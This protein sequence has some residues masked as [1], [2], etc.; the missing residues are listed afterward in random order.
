MAWTAFEYPNP[1]R[2]I[3]QVVFETM[4]EDLHFERYDVT[5][6]SVVDL[7]RNTTSFTMALS[8]VAVG[9]YTLTWRPLDTLWQQRLLIQR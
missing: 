4:G 2:G 7:G 1:S 6:R 3:V 8:Q 5:I 9:Y